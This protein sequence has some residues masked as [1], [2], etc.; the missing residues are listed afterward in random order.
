MNIQK[1]V[2]NVLNA[3]LLSI[4]LLGANTFAADKWL[5]PA[6]YP[7][8]MDTW[9]GSVYNKTAQHDYRDRIGGWG[10]Q[11]SS[12]LRF[13]LS[14]LPQVATSA[15]IWRYTINEGTPTAINWWKI[16]EQWQSSTVGYTNFPWGTLLSLGTTSAPSPGYWYT[17][18]ITTLY[19]QWRTGTTG[20]LN[21]GL[22]MTPV[23]TNNNYSSFYSSTQGGGYGPW[24]QVTYTP[25]SND[26]V[27]KLKWPLSTAKPATPSSGGAFGDPW[28]TGITKCVGQP[29]THAGV[30][31]PNAVGNPVYAMEDG[32]VKEVLPASQT[33][34]WASAIVLEH[35]HPV[36]GKF[37]TVSWHVTELS[38][39]VPGAFV[40][41]GMQIA[42]IANISPHGS[43][44]HIGVRIGAYNSTYSDKGA[45]PTGYC[46]ELATFQENFI[47]PWTQVLFQ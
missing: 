16:N 45:L 43:H 22:L 9:F 29:M 33:G 38:G 10:D 23:S 30:D 2:Q 12:L 21:Y 42:T 46:S 36:S 8:G 24:I 44:L 39:I 3:L 19:N 28:G 15:L 47:N 13:D 20:S 37:T 1:T 27:I 4:F 7:V 17:T 26:N 25:Q 18:N 41:K 5:N 11:Y 14:G 32:V 6:P 40:P 31:I 35:N 34:G